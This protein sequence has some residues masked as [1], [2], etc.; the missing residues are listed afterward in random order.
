M[1]LNN[2]ING[3]FPHVPIIKFYIRV[4]FQIQTRFCANLSVRVADLGHTVNGN[5]KYCINKPYSKLNLWISERF[6]WHYTLLHTPI[7][8]HTKILFAT[9]YHLCKKKSVTKLSHSSQLHPW[10]LHLP[11]FTYKYD[12]KIASIESNHFL[13]VKL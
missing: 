1:T 10:T 7:I 8:L 4:W 3:K 13:L 5:R 12:S 11:F 9:A 6:T 2:K